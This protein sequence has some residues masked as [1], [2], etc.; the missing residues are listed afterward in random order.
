MND[1]CFF[2]FFCPLEIHFSWLRFLLSV[3]GKSFKRNCGAPADADT[4]FK[5]GMAISVNCHG[6]CP[7]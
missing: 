6:P 2:L 3:L 7:V 5:V 1:E 4:S